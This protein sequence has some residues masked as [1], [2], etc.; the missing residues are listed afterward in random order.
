MSDCTST[1][2]DE[3]GFRIEAVKHLN[4][5]ASALSGETEIE[6]LKSEN[7]AL[8][9]ELEMWR[10]GAVIRKEDHSELLQLRADKE[11]VGWCDKNPSGLTLLGTSIGE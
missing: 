8:R 5:V 2:M 7:A 11:R 4:E 10:D 6:R 1:G 3:F 9:A